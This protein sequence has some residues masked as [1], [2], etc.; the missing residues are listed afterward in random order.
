[1]TLAYRI[2]NWKNIGEVTDKGRAAQEDTPNDRIRKT[3]P[4]YI[5]WKDSFALYERLCGFW[6]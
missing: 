2:I 4:T 6:Q 1:M 5:R 3:R